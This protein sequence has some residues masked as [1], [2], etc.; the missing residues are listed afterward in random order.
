[1]NLIEFKEKESLV[2]EKCVAL[3]GSYQL[4]IEP[5][6][7]SNNK[8]TI[9]ED[10]LVIPKSKKFDSFIFFT[11]I[12]NNMYFAVVNLKDIVWEKQQGHR[13]KSFKI[14]VNMENSVEMFLNT[15]QTKKEEVISEIRPSYYKTDSA[16]EP[17][18]IIK[19]YGLNFNLGNV[20]KY[21]LRAGEKNKQTLIE[22]LKKAITYLQFEI[23]DHEEK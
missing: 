10:E 5:K 11:E 2:M 15:A 17:R 12:H 23:E 9:F 6:G 4:F 13:N 8:L 22:D 16:Y 1:M 21:T 20:I 18:K 7:I 3:K 14:L 19:H